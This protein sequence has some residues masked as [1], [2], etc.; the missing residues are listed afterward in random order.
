MG[1]IYVN[2]SRL[3][4]T[5]VL[6][7][8]TAGFFPSHLSAAGNAAVTAATAHAFPAGP[9]KEGASTTLVRNNAGVTA[10]FLSPDLKVG[11][12]YTL[13]WV[14]VN[15]PANCSGGACN[16]DDVVPFPGNTAAGVSLLYGA[17]HVIPTSGRGNFAAHLA[18]GDTTGAMFG[19]GLVDPLGAEIHLVLRTHG[20]VIPGALDEQLS[21]F[22][23][24][25]SV[26]T[27]ANEISAE[28][29]PLTDQNSVDL[30]AVKSLL[31]RVA[32]RQGLRP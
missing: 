19:P 14:I 9:I 27:C 18:V 1:S 24:G 17:G 22:A 23:G 15:Q 8:L 6:L 16:L 29:K 30:Q 26:N 21:S 7:I 31:E 28:H 11:D 13:W 3:A 20:P 10:T 4:A 2:T 25:C 12:V 5:A 32:Q